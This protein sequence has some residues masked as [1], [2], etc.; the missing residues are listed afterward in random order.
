M[1]DTKSSRADGADRSQALMQ[2]FAI[3]ALLFSPIVAFLITMLIRG[4]YRYGVASTRWFLVLYVPHWPRTV[5][6]MVNKN[7]R[8]VPL[9]QLGM[10]ITYS[11]EGRLRGKLNIVIA[12]IST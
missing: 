5:S 2:I 11:S 9:G 1:C 3:Y 12:Y 10:E 4:N 7:P 8:G 6:E